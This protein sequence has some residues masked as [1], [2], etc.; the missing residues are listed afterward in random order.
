MG[1]YIDRSNSGFKSALSGTIQ[2]VDKSGLIA[3][4]NANIDSEQRFLCITRPRRFGKTL[5]AQMI[6]PYYNRACN[7]RDLFA[8]L[9]IARDPSY[10]THLN[11]Y[12][13]IFFDVQEQR[14]NVTRGDDFVAYL[15]E[16]IGFEL[17][18]LWPNETQNCHTI[19][20]ML[21]QIHEHTQTKF[22]IILDEWHAI[23]RMDQDNEHAI[24]MWIDFLRSLFK[25]PYANDY[26][27][28]AYMTGVLPIRRFTSESPL[29]NFYEYTVFNTYPIG[30]FYGFTEN[31][32]KSLCKKYEMNYDEMKRW[33]DGYL[34]QDQYMYNPNS[35]VKA[36]AFRNIIGYWNET[37]K[38]TP[39]RRPIS[40]VCNAQTSAS[41]PR[42][43]HALHE[44]G[45]TTRLFTTTTRGFFLFALANDARFFV[46]TTTLE[47]FHHAFARHV[48]LELIDGTTEV[49]T[50]DGNL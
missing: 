24:L 8:N 36:I 29:N 44:T 20:E 49:R 39:R 28:L 1:L 7:S 47:F 12:P 2:Y 6:A 45:T 14:S 41:R 46:V 13:V 33:Y 5:A 27:A 31:E 30:Q 23:Y 26:I 4:L 16:K 40:K 21:A 3:H 34:Y 50:F 38:A 48:A 17:K 10:E 22:V 35:V 32:V 25:G 15:Q 37:K 18:K 43:S 11:R 19:Q 9:D 42:F